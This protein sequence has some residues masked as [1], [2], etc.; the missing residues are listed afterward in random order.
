MRRELRVIWS[1]PG[2][3]TWRVV[4]AIGIVGG[5]LLA[6]APSR[7]VAADPPPYPVVTAEMTSG[8]S[9]QSM[10]GGPYVTITYT[11][12]LT[13]AGLADA[14]GVSVT[15][16]VPDGAASASASNGGVVTSTTVTWT[17][18]S[19]PAAGTI[20]VTLLVTVDRG[21]DGTVVSDHATFTNVNTPPD[22]CIQSADTTSGTCDTNTT[23]LTVAFWLVTVTQD[24]LFP[25]DKQPVFPGEKITYKFTMMNTGHAAGGGQVSD[26]IPTGTTHVPGSATPPVPLESGALY[27]NIPVPPMSGTTPG[28]AD[29][30]FQVSVDASAVGSTLSNDALLGD[31]GTT[32]LTQGYLD[33]HG[34]TSRACFTNTVS[35]SVASVPPPAPVEVAFQGISGSL[36]SVGAAGLADWNV[37][38]A[39][40]SSPSMTRLPNGGFLVAFQGYGGDLWTVGTA[41]WTDWHVGVAPGTSPSV[42]ALPTGDF[43][44]AFQ[45]YGGN[46][47]SVGSA[48]WVNWRVG[49]A[50]GTSPSVF[51][52]STGGYEIAFQAHGGN[53]W[54]VG[55]AGWTDWHLGI[56]PA[57][58]PAAAR[59]SN[60]G[61]EI[62]FQAYGG[63]LWTVG[64]TGWTKWGVGM[65]SGTS[66]SLTA[67]P[68]GGFEVAF[69]GYDANLWTVGNAGWTDWPMSVAATTSPTAS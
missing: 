43:E 17:N 69:Q 54:T 31:T 12:Q 68:R 49:M 8:Q 24:E 38:L 30:S 62:G 25:G 45:A 47:W 39:P 29:L 27:W 14:T 61:Y 50:S 23:S 51:A 6:V 57:T 21:F 48:G 60:G 32:A 16:S 59:L 4:A 63:A 11:I 34:G 18:L 42:V 65:A 20:S 13:N 2:A 5:S 58:S 52:P 64:T 37:G 3:L 55:T 28:D 44:V 9:P 1:K 19:V 46:L 10:F 35:N 56:A 15:A 66:P 7:A 26:H 22:Q 53:L 36:R 40:A 41:G 67:L 33:C